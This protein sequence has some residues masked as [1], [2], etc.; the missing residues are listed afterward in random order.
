[1]KRLIATL[2][3]DFR[4]QWRNGFYMVTAFVVAFWGLLATQL[5]HDGLAPFLPGIIMGNLLINTFYYVAGLVLLEKGEGTLEVQVVTPLRK[6]EYLLSKLITLSAL[7]LVENL[8]IVVFWAGFGFRLL[9]LALGILLA[10]ALL[11][12]LGFLAVTRYNSINEFLLPSMLYT[13]LLLVPLM[14]AFGLVSSPLFYL[15]PSH[16]ALVLMRAAFQPVESGIIIYGLLFSAA[17]VGLAFVLGQR[18]FHRF[19][20]MVQGAD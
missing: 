9:P 4:L 11:I 2:L 8:L 18:A 12:L 13:T 20:V 7:S 6:S 19:I 3:C 16:A 5:P 17:S 10:S 14:E 15:H 1:M